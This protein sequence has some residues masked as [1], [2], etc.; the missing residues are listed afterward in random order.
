MVTESN[1]SYFKIFS[2]DDV[3]TWVRKKRR[4]QGKTKCIQEINSSKPAEHIH[5]SHALF[6]R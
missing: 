2:V 6:E 4:A 3:G 1:F 5:S